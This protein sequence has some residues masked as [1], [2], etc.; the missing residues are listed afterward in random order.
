M[1]ATSATKSAAAIRRSS[2]CC[3]AGSPGARRR[4]EHS[5]GDRNCTEPGRHSRDRRARC[6]RRVARTSRAHRR[7][8]DRGHPSR[9]GR[10]PRVLPPRQCRRHRAADHLHFRPRQPHR[11]RPG[12][13]G[14]RFR[15]PR[16]A[17]HRRKDCGHGEALS[18]NVESSGAPAPGAIA[19]W[20]RRNRR[21]L[22]CHS[23]S[24]RGGNEGRR[25][26]RLRTDNRR[27]RCGQG[28]GGQL[29]PRAQRARRRT[30]RQGELLGDFGEPRGKRAVRSRARRV[31]RRGGFEK[32]VVRDRAR[33][34]DLS[35]RDRGSGGQRAGQDPARPCRTAKFSGSARNG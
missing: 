28:A 25:D 20:R 1:V 26:Q 11:S 14:R 29:Y 31:H 19:A 27:K 30:F 8:D 18:R 12:G 6:R 34:R 33:W 3:H 4:E 15:F 9:R 22:G 5:R 16:E 13:E 21:R 10:R 2:W 17:V 24:G 32:R 7:R 23:Q 35:R